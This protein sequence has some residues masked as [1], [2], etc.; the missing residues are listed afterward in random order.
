[1]AHA[2]AS[3]PCRAPRLSALSCVGRTSFVEFCAHP[4]RCLLPPSVRRTCRP[5]NQTLAPSLVMSE[6]NDSSTPAGRPVGGTPQLSSPLLCRPASLSSPA[7]SPAPA[8]SLWHPKFS[9]PTRDTAHGGGTPLTLA[10]PLLCR[11]P[12][13]TCTR[14]NHSCV[15]RWRWSARPAALAPSDSWSTTTTPRPPPHRAVPPSHRGRSLSVERPASGR[16]ETS[17][18]QHSWAR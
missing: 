7:P 1:M 9:R 13:R 12:A 8:C 10:G 14:S 18:S 3:R 16:R 2:G 6:A 17:P 4:G 15:A 5:T 11:P